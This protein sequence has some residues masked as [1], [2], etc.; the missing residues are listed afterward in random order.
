ME[1]SD[2]AKDQP[3]AQ[4]PDAAG[5]ANTP[6]GDLE[7]QL[8]SARDEAAEYKDKYLRALAEMENFRKRQERVAVDRSERAKRDVLAKVLDVLDNVDRAMRY[9]ETLD[10]DGLLQTLRMM[11]WQLNELLKHEGVSPV[12]AAG[13]PF[14]PRLHEAIETVASAEHPEGTVVEEV[15]KGYMI[16]GELL[17]PARVKVSDGS[18]G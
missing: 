1:E 15:R 17:R 18:N 2:L 11:Q 4:E 3:E 10:R 14:D 12:T 7:A 5:N 16:G 6:A 8:Q 13:E 9:E